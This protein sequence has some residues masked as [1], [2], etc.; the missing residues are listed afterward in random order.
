MRP[1]IYCTITVSCFLSQIIHFPSRWSSTTAKACGIDSMN[2]NWVWCNVAISLCIFYPIDYNH[3]G[4]ITNYWNIGFGLFP[5]YTYM[6]CASSN[7]IY[8]DDIFSS[9]TYLVVSCKQFIHSLWKLYKSLTFAAVCHRDLVALT[10]ISTS[11]QT[12]SKRKER[13]FTRIVSHNLEDVRTVCM[14]DFKIYRSYSTS[15]TSIAVLLHNTAVC[16]ITWLPRCITLSCCITCCP[17]A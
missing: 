9:T 4:D 6:I 5:M 17:A 7:P 10:I 8:L 2:S 15:L 14:P 16:C 1:S 12:S 11:P 3:L 13:A